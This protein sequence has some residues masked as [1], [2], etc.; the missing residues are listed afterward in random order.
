L[1]PPLPVHYKVVDSYFAND[2][3]LTGTGTG[4]RLEYRDID[5]SFLEMVGT[6]V[7]D[8]AITLERD[9]TKRS[10]LHPVSG[11]AAAKVG[12]GLF[13]TSQE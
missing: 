3:R 7:T 8:R 12:A 1:T 4:A 5:P 9:M 2:R 13:L 6:T 10:Y 11:S